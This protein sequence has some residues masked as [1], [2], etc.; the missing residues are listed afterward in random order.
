MFL[1]NKRGIVF[2][3]IFFRIFI[4]MKNQQNFQKHRSEVK[5]IDASKLMNDMRQELIN[6]FSLKQEAAE[7]IAIETEKLA[8]K[9][10]YRKKF[11]L[12]ES[13]FYNQFFWLII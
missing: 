3:S 2:I 8:E 9:Y 11:I 6:M 13:C 7:R 1:Q 4:Y 5:Q 10:A 12:N